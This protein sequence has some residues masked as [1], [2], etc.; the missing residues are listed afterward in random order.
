MKM[1]LF[2]N[3][4]IFSFI[5]LSNFCYI[6]LEWKQKKRTIN[7]RSSELNFFPS[8]M[9]TDGGVSYTRA[10]TLAYTLTTAETSLQ[11]TPSV[12]FLGACQ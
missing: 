12:A 3:W 9:L 7:I 11:R 4:A 6:R 2:A 1:N 8:D 5:T 10:C